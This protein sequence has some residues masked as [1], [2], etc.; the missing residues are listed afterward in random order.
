MFFNFYAKIEYSWIFFCKML[1]KKSM[2]LT[3]GSDTHIMPFLIN[4]YPI[5]SKKTGIS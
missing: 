5:V 2:P 4:I 3:N 1:D